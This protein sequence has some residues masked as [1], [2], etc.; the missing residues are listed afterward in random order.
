MDKK[1]LEFDNQRKIGT[2]QRYF[3]MLICLGIYGLKLSFN[4]VSKER[5]NFIYLLKNSGFIEQST[6]EN[7][8]YNLKFRHG[9]RIIYFENF[10]GQLELN[11]EGMLHWNLFLQTNI[12][13]TSRFLAISMSNELFKTKNKIHQTVRIQ[14]LTDFQRCQRKDLFWIPNSN[15]YPGYF[16]RITVQFLDLVKND[17]VQEAIKASPNKYLPYISKVDSNFN[18]IENK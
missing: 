11:E 16:A 10:D 13:T 7:T 17:Q 8:L 6:L 1:N 4:L 2:R 18:Q 5:T 9:N 3:Q 14:P 12:L 15:Y